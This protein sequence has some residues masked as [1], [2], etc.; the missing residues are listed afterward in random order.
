MNGPTTTITNMN[1]QQAKLIVSK[2][3][4]F[5][6]HALGTYTESLQNSDVL[7]VTKAM[8]TVEVEIKTHR[9]DLL[10]ELHTI[11][12]VLRDDKPFGLRQ[13]H[14]KWLKHNSYLKHPEVVTPNTFIPNTY[15][16]AIPDTMYDHR[17]NALRGTPYGVMLIHEDKV[18]IVM[19]A[20][21]MHK[22]KLLPEH[23]LR[24]MRKTATENYFL[25]KKIVEGGGSD[26]IGTL[27]DGQADSPLYD[28]S[29]SPGS[30]S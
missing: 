2:H 14:V 4:L 19:E 24:L 13:R 17:L 7:A 29:S 16:I 26:E 23:L 30:S 8:F 22:N 1:S 27:S 6:L 9:E 20:R 11:T 5:D 12:K 15:Y 25:R 10:N 28:T 21:K 18:E 3:F